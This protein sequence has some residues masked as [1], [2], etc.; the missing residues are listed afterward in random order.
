L[1]SQTVLGLDFGGTKIAVAACDETGTALATTSIEMLAH[2]GARSGFD[3]AVSAARALLDEAAPGR[4]LVAV[5]VS[6][7]GVPSAS[8]TA[9]APAVP[10]WG[11]LSLTHELGRAFPGAEILVATDVKAAA[12]FEAERGA[13]VGCDPGLY[14]N[15]G[16]G[17]AVAI[18]VGGAVLL[19]RH[20]ASGE[21]GYNL[22]RVDDVRRHRDE[23]TM[24]EDTVSGGAFLRAARRLA[25]GWDTAEAIFAESDHS[26]P[27]ADLLDN[28]LDE[29]GFHLVNLAIAIDPQRIAVGGGMVRSWHRI[30][31]RLRQALE[32]AVP[33]PPDLVP[34][35]FP[36]D[37]PLLGAV[38]LATDAARERL[39]R[40]SAAKGAVTAPRSPNRTTTT[41]TSASPTELKKGFSA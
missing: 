26:G 12:Q 23:R 4:E 14:L 29:L 7:I 19:G 15:L 10:G 33:F 40:T 31:G 35:A 27:I 5:G 25:P 2:Q 3:R 21:I 11:D 41:H 24:L 6:T 1:A 16:T 22:R 30:E 8:G 38:S 18:V 39:T 28:F 20:G 37:A 32:S 13:L 17:L 9:L 34:G 36:F